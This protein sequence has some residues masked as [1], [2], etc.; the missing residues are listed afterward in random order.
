MLLE[1]YSTKLVG[2]KFYNVVKSMYS[3]SEACVKLERGRIDFFKI[4]LGV[5]QGDSLSPI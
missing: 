2:S 3:S 5:K 4:K 1:N